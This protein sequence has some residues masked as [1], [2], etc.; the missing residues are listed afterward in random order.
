MFTYNILFSRLC[1]IKAQADISPIFARDRFLISY[2][3]VVLFAGLTGVCLKEINQALKKVTGKCKITR[4]IDYSSQ[5]L[6]KFFIA[7]INPAPILGSALVE[8]AKKA[9]AFIKKKTD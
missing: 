6:T 8:G 5:M 4:G 3:S 9:Y 1:V 7:H 2:F